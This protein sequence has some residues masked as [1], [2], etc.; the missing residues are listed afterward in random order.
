MT[1]SHHLASVFRRLQIYSPL[2]QLRKIKPKLGGITFSVVS[3][4]NVSDDPVHQPR[5]ELEHVGEMHY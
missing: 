2:K 1:F 5:L 3:F 4:K